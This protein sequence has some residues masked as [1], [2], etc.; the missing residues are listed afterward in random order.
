MNGAL[1]KTLQGTPA[2]LYPGLGSAFV[3]LADESLAPGDRMA[4]VLP[5]MM[6]TGS[7]RSG[8]RQ[9]LLSKYRIEWVIVS[10]AIRNRSAVKGLPGRWLVSFSEATRIT[11]VLIVATK[12]G[13]NL[14]RNHARFVNLVRNPDEPVQAMTLIRKLLAMDKNIVPLE[15]RTIDVREMNWGSM[16]AVPQRD[17]SDSAWS[18]AA[19]APS[20]LVLVA[21]GMRSGSNGLLTGIPIVELESIADLDPYHM[22]KKS[23]AG[24][25]QNC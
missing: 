14:N 9:L 23:R 1:Q 10:H 6:P 19:L 18:Y 22:W 13:A 24:V 12:G 15:S 4:F 16:V 3:V 11:E 5:A 21:E 17:L 7:R 20:E 25:V 2:S 8:I